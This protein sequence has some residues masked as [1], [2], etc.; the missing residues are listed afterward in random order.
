VQLE[1]DGQGQMAVV[2]T[3]HVKEPKEVLP[4]RQYLDRLIAA[5]H[6]RNLPEAYVKKLEAI[7]AC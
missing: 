6:N 3:V 5:A 2:Y 4:S 1:A 7:V